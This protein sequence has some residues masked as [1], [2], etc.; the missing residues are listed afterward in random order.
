MGEKRVHSRKKRTFPRPWDRET[1][2]VQGELVVVTYSAVHSSRMMVLCLRKMEY[3]SKDCM[4][5]KLCEGHII[6]TA[7]EEMDTRL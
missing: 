7:V 4:I 2:W 6:L 5:R 3:T 1:V